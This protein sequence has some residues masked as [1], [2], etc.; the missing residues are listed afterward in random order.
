VLA[1]D[2]LRNFGSQT[3]EHLAVGVD[4][5]PLVCGGAGRGGKGLHGEQIGVVDSWRMGVRL[6]PGFLQ[7]FNIDRQLGHVN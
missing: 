5:E 2:D 4:D 7:N 1:A 6:P 3:S